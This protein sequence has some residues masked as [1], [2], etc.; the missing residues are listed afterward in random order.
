MLKTTVL[1]AGLIAC[2]F[3]ANAF[4]VPGE[5]TT[6]SPAA[7]A[8]GEITSKLDQITKNNEDILKELEEI[9]KELYIIKIRASR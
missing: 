4:A 9:K 3:T 1:T 5:T 7:S 6:A 2:V 8:K